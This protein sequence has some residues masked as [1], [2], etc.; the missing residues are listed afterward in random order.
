MGV[1]RPMTG[2]LLWRLATGQTCASWRTT[3]RCGKLPRHNGFGASG[4][5]APT[6]AAAVES[7]QTRCMR[8]RAR[9]PGAVLAARFGVAA[10]APLV[11]R[12]GSGGARAPL[13]QRRGAPLEL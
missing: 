9:R 2:L 7:P 1:I 11:R 8:A 3:E 6:T 12:A 13:M 4:L 10:R 5:R